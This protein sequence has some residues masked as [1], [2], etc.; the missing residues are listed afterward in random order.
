MIRFMWAWLMAQMAW[1]EEFWR[2]HT[3]GGRPRYDVKKCKVRKCGKWI[4]SGTR[5]RACRAQGRT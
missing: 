1:R 2:R 5:C 4:Y 3:G